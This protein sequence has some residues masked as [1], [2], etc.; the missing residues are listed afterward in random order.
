MQV[1]LRFRDIQV[2]T[3]KTS[4]VDVFSNLY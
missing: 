2:N 4:I 3:G 1:M